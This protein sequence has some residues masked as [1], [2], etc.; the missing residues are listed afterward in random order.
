MKIFYLLTIILFAVLQCSSPTDFN[1]APEFISTTPVVTGI[2][3]TNINGDVLGEIGLP[4]DGHKKLSIKNKYPEFE[5]P[6][7]SVLSVLP[8]SINV[9]RIYPNPVNGPVIIKYHLPKNLYVKIW[10]V[11]ASYSTAFLGNMLPSVSTFNKST[12]YSKLIRPKSIQE[13]GSY[14]VVWRTEDLNSNYLPNGFYR[15][16]I[17]IDNHL[18]WRDLLLL[19]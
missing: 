5:T 3:Q 14:S 12:V 2:Y 9:Y 11:R 8:F 13:P 18:F 10:A 16:Y 15:I 6:P 4:S 7:D 17:Q 1:G 19:Y